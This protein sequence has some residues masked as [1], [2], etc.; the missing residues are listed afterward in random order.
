MGVEGEGDWETPELAGADLRQ[1]STIVATAGQDIPA[2]EAIRDELRKREG[3]D[4]DELLGSVAWRLARLRRSGHPPSIPPAGSQPSRPRD[5]E[6]KPPKPDD[7]LS[8]F[9]RARSLQRSD[10]RSLHRYGATRAE[11]EALRAF[12]AEAHRRGRLS[13]ARPRDAAAFVLYGAEWFRNAFDG[14]NASWVALTEG[15]GP[16]SHTVIAELADVGLKWWKLRVHRFK[17]ANEWFL[18]LRFEAGF[19]ARVLAASEQHWLN[20]HMRGLIA[21]CLAASGAIDEG[22]I[23]ALAAANARVPPSFR[24]PVF[25][26]LCAELA[27]RVAAL[28]CDHAT[29]A[30]AAGLRISIWL[31]VER[32]GWREA[33]GV[34]EGATTLIDGLVS[35]S[36][37]RLG[38]TARCRRLLVRDADGWHPALELGVEGE[39]RLPT[40][41]ADRTS[42][43]HAFPSGR[44][45]DVLAGAVCTLEPPGRDGSWLAR[46]RAA[47]PRRPLLDFP[48]SAS[49]ALELRSEGQTLGPIGWNGGDP[50]RTE[51]LSFA[52]DGEGQSEQLVLVAGG[53]CRSRHLELFVWTPAAYRVTDA[54]SGSVVQ[55]IWSGGGRSLHRAVRAVH[56]G[57]AHD[58]APFRIQPGAGTDEAD[59]IVV[60]GV[61]VGG[62]CTSAG[63]P[64]YAGAPSVIIRRGSMEMAAD[65]DV[66]WHRAGSALWHKVRR[67]TIGDGAVDV[68]W[69][70]GAR[71]RAARDRHRLTLLPGGTVLTRKAAP[72]GSA[73]FCLEGAGDWCPQKTLT[74]GAALEIL[75]QEFGRV[76]FAVTWAGPA[77]RKVALRLVAA[78]RAALDVTAAVP[79]GA[80]RFIGADGRALRN[81]ASVTIEALRGARAV[82]DGLRTLR[83]ELHKADFHAD[84]VQTFDEELS[85]W[86][87]RDEIST[88]LAA[89]DGIDAEVR[90]GFEPSG[91]MLHVHRYTYDFPH[92]A[93]RM[94]ELRASA[95][96]TG[97]R[98][99]SLLDAG[100]AGSREIARFV[101]GPPAPGTPFR[102]PADLSG[103]GLIYLV[104]DGL[105]IS[106]PR[107]VPGGPLPDDQHTT[108]LKRAVLLARPQERDA[109]LNAALTQL[110]DS[111]ITWLHAL[112]AQPDALPASAFDVLGRLVRN[113]GALATLAV[114][115]PNAAGRSRVWGLEQELPFLWILVGIEE[116]RLAFGAGRDRMRS[117]LAPTSLA[118]RADELADQHIR[119]V[120]ALLAELDEDLRTPLCLAGALPETSL[121]HR[122]LEAI[123]RDHVMFRGG[124]YDR[125]GATP[126]FETVPL[127]PGLQRLGAWLTRFDRG[128]HELLE[129]PLAAAL[130]A[131]DPTL[132]LT[133]RQLLRIRRAMAQDP[134]Y[135]AEAYGSALREITDAARR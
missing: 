27:I 120:A 13:E 56:A 90:I 7:V 85:L 33:L 60:R 74:S 112:L 125:H 5:D 1:L 95:D 132:P 84:Y 80:G 50:V 47:A 67:V 44:L 94:P 20:H 116:W 70:D 119:D 54:A 39:V 32:P 38:G 92:G 17:G 51:V 69:R 129:A 87:L 113:T 98:W 86:S 34:G 82:A 21:A 48:F 66:E 73:L 42:R 124:A 26:A 23:V 121:A 35:D 110:H 62:L 28:R 93:P 109:A 103:P 97:L 126:C 18:T 101:E 52:P 19:P 45:A 72:N 29:A 123:A 11:V 89:A 31:D 22:E 99:R 133:P 135:F 88:L 14:K 10:G 43:L 96:A 105:A 128:F 118:H 114:S 63:D 127:M 115:A 57:R 131:L 111:D 83:L 58:D 53:S 75:T 68:V 78:G 15:F 122:S 24:T 6:P 9:L 64:V 134:Q 36:F 100:E 108:P 71:S 8:A 77:Q 76:A 4:V 37:G 59:Q 49:V 41:F 107:F 2:L 12:L 79:F 40:A 130:H 3:E 102:L 55:P 30:A 65:D 61:E 16:L 91:D 25:A 81:N 106:R 46:P 117:Y 104:K